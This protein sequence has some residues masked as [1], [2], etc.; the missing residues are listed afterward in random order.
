MS[1]SI[2]IG[3]SPFDADAG[4]MLDAAVTAEESGYGGVWTMDHL[5]GVVAGKASSMEAF[6]LLGA[7]AARTTSVTVGVLVANQRNRHPAV[8]AASMATLQNLSGGRAMLGIG[9]G[10]GPRGPYA[11]EQRAIGRTPEDGETRRAR[12]REVIAI[13]YGLWTDQPFSHA[14]AFYEIDGAVGW[15]VPQPV[16]PIIVGVGGPRAARLAGELADGINVPATVEQLEDI[17][18]LAR[19]AA[20]ERRF[21]VTAYAS[22]SDEAFAPSGTGRTRLEQLGVDR[23]VLFTTQSFGLE[24]ITRLARR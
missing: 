8:L 1:L 13:Q 21:L 20:G 4:W 6:T 17:V 24:S 10:T 16:P 18:G 2:D 15:P 14:G 12:L 5:S 7:I 9:L 19:E 11:S 22:L 23:L 3:L